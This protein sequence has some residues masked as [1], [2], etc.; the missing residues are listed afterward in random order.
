MPETAVYEDGDVPAREYD[1][2]PY[3]CYAEVNALV[4]PIPISGGVDGR[5]KCPLRAGISSPDGLHISSSSW[6][7][8]AGSLGSISV[9]R[10]I[11]HVSSGILE[12]LCAQD[13]AWGADYSSFDSRRSSAV[14]PRFDLPRTSVT[15]R[16]RFLFI[17]PT[18]SGAGE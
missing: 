5:A 7:H 12:T 2:G 10:Q 13:L 18:F 8:S 14:N 4:V 3:S 11:G 9:N 15:Y 6:T 1:I 17:A 16:L